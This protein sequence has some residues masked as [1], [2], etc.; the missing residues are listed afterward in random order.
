[1]PRSTMPRDRSPVPRAAWPAVGATRMRGGAGAGHASC[2]ARST[3]RRREKSGV[4]SAN[5]GAVDESD[6]AL[7]AMMARIE[8]EQGV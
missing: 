4:I 5:L 6:P 7:H 1:M 8:A 2:V 3:P